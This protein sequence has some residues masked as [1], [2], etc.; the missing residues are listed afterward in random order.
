VADLILL[1]TFVSIQFWVYT[2]WNWNFLF[3]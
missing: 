2:L 3:F 1:V